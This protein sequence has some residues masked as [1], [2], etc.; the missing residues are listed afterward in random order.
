MDSELME[1]YSEHDVDDKLE[2]LMHC[3]L[4]DECIFRALNGKE[5]VQRSWLT[6]R[7]YEENGLPGLF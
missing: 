1:K 4:S 3:I 5:D 7:S 6:F 2:M